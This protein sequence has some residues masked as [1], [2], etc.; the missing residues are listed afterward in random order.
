[1]RALASDGTF[2]SLRQVT[3]PSRTLCMGTSGALDPEGQ[4]RRTVYDVGD[5]QDLPGRVARREARS[6]PGPPTCGCTRLRSRKPHTVL[7]YKPIGDPAYR[8]LIDAIDAR[9]KAL[10]W[11]LRARGSEGDRS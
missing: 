5:T 6:D 8:A 1:M 9:K 3:T 2:R 4:K 10:R 7:V 11:A